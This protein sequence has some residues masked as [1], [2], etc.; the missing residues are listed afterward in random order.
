MTSQMS[1]QSWRAGLYCCLAAA[2]LCLAAADERSHKVRPDWAQNCACWQGSAALLEPAGQHNVHC[3]SS[4]AHHVA[5]PRSVQ[6]AVAEPVRIWV[7]KAGPYN[8]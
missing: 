5:L 2:L 3:R 8:K 4:S 7:N 6:Y 1:R